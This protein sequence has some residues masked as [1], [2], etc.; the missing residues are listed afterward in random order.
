MPGAKGVNTLPM[1]ERILLPFNHENAFASQL[2]TDPPAIF[3]LRVARLLETAIFD[4]L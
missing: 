4:L 1:L 2:L 3:D